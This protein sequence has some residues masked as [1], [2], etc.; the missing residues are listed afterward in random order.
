MTKWKVDGPSWGRK[1]AVYINLWGRGASSIERGRVISESR[2]LCE[3]GRRQIANLVASGYAVEI[4]PEKPQSKYA[5]P[6]LGKK[7]NFVDVVAEVDDVT[8]S[9]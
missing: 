7:P 2:A 1:T 4:K 8:E 5:K 9:Q 6:P 3:L